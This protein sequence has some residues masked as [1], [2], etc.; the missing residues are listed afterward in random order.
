MLEDGSIVRILFGFIPVEMGNVRK[1]LNDA[2]SVLSDHLKLSGREHG[3]ITQLVVL[4]GSGLVFSCCPGDHVYLENLAPTMASIE[5][6]SRTP[7]ISPVRIV[8][9]IMPVLGAGAG[10]VELSS[11]DKVRY[12][13]AKR[14]ASRACRSGFE[15]SSFSPPM[16][17][18][19]YLIKWFK[20][21]Y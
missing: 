16:S 19:G 18:F 2:V 4:S 3:N 6:D 7:A 14:I 13:E 12:D 15:A 10:K 11:V 17:S 5:G 8:D 20:D 21:N 1:E 9:A